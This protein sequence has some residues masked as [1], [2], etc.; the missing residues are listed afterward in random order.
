MTCLSIKS[1]I[2]SPDLLSVFYLAFAP[3]WRWHLNACCPMPPNVIH[4]PRQNCAYIFR[5]LIIQ[6]IFLCMIEGEI[7]F[8]LAILPHILENPP[9]SC[10]PQSILLQNKV[11][12]IFQEHHHKLNEHWMAVFWVWRL[13]YL[14]LWYLISSSISSCWWVRVCTICHLEVTGNDT[15]CLHITSLTLT[16]A[17]WPI[18]QYRA[19]SISLA[20]LTNPTTYCATHTR[21]I[22]PNP[23]RV[24]LLVSCSWKH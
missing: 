16:L 23:L 20:W 11:W 22:L 21:L 15:I 9:L 5:I 12:H 10:F 3:Y 4:T 19:C 2:T 14:T 6:F 13:P 24:I 17:S 7:P 1:F 8:F 18:F